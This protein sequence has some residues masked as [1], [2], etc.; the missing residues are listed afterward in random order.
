MKNS[1]LIYLLFFYLVNYSSSTL[2]NSIEK[3][4]W[5]SSGAFQIVDRFLTSDTQVT[6]KLLCAESSVNLNE[7]QEQIRKPL[8]NNYGKTKI[9]ITGR[10]GRVVGCLPLQSDAFMTTNQSS[11]K[12]NKVSRTISEAF[13][14]NLWKQMEVREFTMQQTNCDY[15]GE[16][17]F[18]EYKNMT[19][20]EA[21]ADIR[22]NILK[23]EREQIS[24]NQN[25]YIPPRRRR[26]RRRGAE[27]TNIKLNTKQSSSAAA[28]SQP[29]EK[30]LRTWT[31][32]YYLIEIFPPVFLESN[33]PEL[34]V[35]VMVSM[36]N[37][38]G[39]YITADEY[40]ALIFYGVMCGIYALFAILWLIWCALY[41]CELLKIQFWIGGV[42]LIGMI[43]KSAYLAEYEIVNRYGYKAHVAV[44]TSEVLSCLKRTVARMLFVIIAH[45]YGIVKLR[46]G[47]LKQKVLAMGLLYFLIAATEA[48]LRLNTK[49]DEE[50]NRVLISRIPL[51][52]INV[53]IYYWIFT[54][55]VAT[56]RTLRSTKNIATL[57]DYR[58][59]TSTLIFA[60]I[61]SLFFMAWSLKS[62]FFTTC[63]TN[64]REFW[65]DDAFWHII[66]SLVL[67]HS[68]F[69][70]R[71]SNNN[72]RV[73]FV[74]FPHQSNNDDDA[75]DDD[76]GKGETAVFDSK[77][78]RKATN[79]E[80]GTASK[81]KTQQQVSLNREVNV[82]SVG[83]GGSNG[84]G[85]VEDSLA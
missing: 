55:L 26:R 64:W 81:S 80:N 33:S 75:F 66:F 17:Y 28:L 31:D 29:S 70:F 27:E 6:L 82:S 83:A 45:G 15:P 56:T 60:I 14:K 25:S 30:R 51:A 44:V 68:M 13:Y 18:D 63:I 54:G 85:V 2:V 49:N 36:K 79:I 32:G 8:Y 77:T 53:A 47:P 69:L 5:S 35:N 74:P 40:P 57:N 46:L 20:P 50:N 67:L 4:S 76:E 10:I 65:I 37:R 58:D 52:V 16:L 12:D 21:A 22:K 34:G 61:A 59:F 62:H 11:S 41:W 71:P 72:S 73:A 38:H 3:L 42:I 19:G 84:N 48:I 24:P 23:Q 78:M 9:Q 43:E 39:G 7:I 1:F